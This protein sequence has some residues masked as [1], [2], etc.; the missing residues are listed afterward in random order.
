MRLIPLA[1]ACN[2]ATGQR[3]AVHVDNIARDWFG[4]SV[5]APSR[6]QETFVLHVLG[7]EPWYGTLC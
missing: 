7:A 5:P 6:K 2:L 4:A 1:T 3:W